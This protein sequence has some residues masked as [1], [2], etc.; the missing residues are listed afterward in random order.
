MFAN[1]HPRHYLVRFLPNNLNTS[2][3]SSLTQTQ[4]SAL[5]QT[6]ISKCG[7]Y[8]PMMAMVFKALIDSCRLKFD[9]EQF[10][11]YKRR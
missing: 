9:Q 5:F 10:H 3:F 1:H 7:S 2:V 8:G 6:P 4:I 11:I